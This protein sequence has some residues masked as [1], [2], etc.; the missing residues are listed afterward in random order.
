MTCIGLLPIIVF[1]WFIFMFSTFKTWMFPKPK[2]DYRIHSENSFFYPIWPCALSFPIDKHLNNF[3]T[4]LSVWLIHKYKQ[5]HICMHNHI[6]IS[7]PFCPPSPKQHAISQFG[8]LLFFTY[9]NIPQNARYRH[10]RNSPC[11]FLQFNILE[12]SVWSL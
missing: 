12:A 2:L 9:Q 10:V 3:W 11:S 4:L 7:L 8:T 6:Y 5:I 1:F